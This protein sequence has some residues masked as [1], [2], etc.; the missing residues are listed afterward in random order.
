MAKIKYEIDSNNRL[1]AQGA[2]KFRHVYDGQFKISEKNELI[3]VTESQQIKLSGKWSLDAKLN[4]C[5]TVDG[6]KLVI[7]TEIVDATANELVFVATT[8]NSDNKEQASK[9]I[10]SGIWKADAF[11]RLVFNDE[12]VFPG[13]WTVNNNNN[14]IEYIVVKRPHGID[15]ILRFQG[16]W[17][18]PGHNRMAYIL[19]EDAKSRFDFKVTMDRVT[20][21]SIGGSVN[22]GIKP[23]KKNITIYGKWNIGDGPAIS[24]DVNYGRGVIGPIA[25]KLTKLLSSGKAFVRFTRSA[26]EVE[27]LGGVERRK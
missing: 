9:L 7:A 10:M 14:H 5:L 26:H 11:N 25:V 8:K 2:Y 12:L 27:I 19:S 16:H 13:I 4:L 23:I 18:V 21:N 3:Y 22:I 15:S 20:R 24:F 1:T 17:D 6:N